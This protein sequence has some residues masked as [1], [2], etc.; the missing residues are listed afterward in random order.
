MIEISKNFKN[1]VFQ[2][3]KMWLKCKK[4]NSTYGG[5]LAAWFT[6]TVWL[7]PPCWAP[8]PTPMPPPNPLGIFC[9]GVTWVYCCW[10]DASC[11]FDLS[12][13]IKGLFVVWSCCCCCSKPRWVMSTERSR[14]LKKDLKKFE[15][16]SN[17]L[18]M[19]F[20]LTNFSLFFEKLV[21]WKFLKKGLF[22]SS[23][24]SNSILKSLFNVIIMQW[25][26]AGWTNRHL[27]TDVL[28][29][30]QR[31]NTHLAVIRRKTNKKLSIL[32]KRGR[33]TGK[34]PKKVTCISHPDL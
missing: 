34:E 24:L 11:S 5:G 21:P 31:N 23:P 1:S 15:S 30:L 13:T 20:L 17:F 4:L 14:R 18:Y 7:L 25:N 10:P 29:T 6:G 16:E 28:H 2:R 12:R 3:S 9:C 8:V 32:K 26:L 22:S 19:T 33:G 27:W